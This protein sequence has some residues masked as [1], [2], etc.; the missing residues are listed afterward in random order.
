MKMDTVHTEK[1]EPMKKWFQDNFYFSDE[2]LK[3]FLAL[4]LSVGLLA[5]GVLAVYGFVTDI[6]ELI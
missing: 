5:L 2:P 4:V 3:D 1:G 6:K